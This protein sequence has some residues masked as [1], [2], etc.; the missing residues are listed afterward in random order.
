MNIPFIDLQAQMAPIR[1]DIENRL[2][3]ILDHCGFIMGPEVKQLEQEL[4]QYTKA[5]HS[6]SCASGTDA[7]ILALQAC[8]IKPGDEVIT[9]NFSFFATAETIALLG[10]VP[11]MVD[12]E[13][14]YYNIDVTQIES[15]ISEKTKAIMPVSLYGQPANMTAINQL[16]QKH[17][18]TVIEDAAQSFGSTWKGQKSGN[19]STIGCTS[20]FPAKPLGCYGDGGAIFTNDDSIAEKIECFRN[21]GQQSR[22]FHTEV[23][24][25]GRLDTMQ[26]AILSAKLGIYDTE[27]KNRQD[28]ASNYNERF[29]SLLEHQVQL[30]QVH[31][32]ATHVWAQYTLKVPGR[33]LFQNFLK[34]KGVPTAVHYPQ[35]MSSQPALKGKCRSLHTPIAD[36]CANHVVSLPMHPYMQEEHFETIVAAVL[37]FFNNK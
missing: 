10:A 3:K 24:I 35:T 33:D 2:L 32:E 5:K 8:G 19:L 11:V 29:A 4:C 17:N 1:K 6:F 13:P 23:G 7:L 21:H 16:A 9:T 36:H 22:Y 26:C 15:V 37:D 34:E 28:L 25:N 20:F 30:P 31:S 14:T 18:L 12:I 27:V